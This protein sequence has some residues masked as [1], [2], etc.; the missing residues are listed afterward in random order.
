[1]ASAKLQEF[2]MITIK[3]HNFKNLVE[4]LKDTEE[5][6]MICGYVTQACEKKS[7]KYF[8]VEKSTNVQFYGNFKRHLK[9]IKFVQ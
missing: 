4:I 7:S 6:K 8:V 9:T 5:G 2:Q 1:M 3:V